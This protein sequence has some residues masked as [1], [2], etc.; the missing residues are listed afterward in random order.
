[1]IK[2][3]RFSYQRRAH[4]SPS[5][6]ESHFSHS[7]LIN[8]RINDA[9]FLLKEKIDTRFDKYN[10]VNV[11]SCVSLQNILIFFFYSFSVVDSFARRLGEV[12]SMTLTALRRL[13]CLWWA[14]KRMELWVIVAKYYF[15]YFFK[16]FWDAYGGFAQ[17][18]HF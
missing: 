5:C 10:L 3:I 13:M 9:I 4:K 2:I 12:E 18:D 15:L 1:V 16:S 17:Y 7:P 8:F 6:H 11:K 14:G